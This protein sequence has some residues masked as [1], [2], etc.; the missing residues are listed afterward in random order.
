MVRSMKCSLESCWHVRERM[1]EARF[2]GWSDAEESFFSS[3]T[4]P[5]LVKE[6]VAVADDDD[7]DDDD[8]GSQWTQVQIHWNQPWQPIFSGSPTTK[9]VYTPSFVRLL[10]QIQSNMTTLHR[11]RLTH[12]QWWFVTCQKMLLFHSQNTKVFNAVSASQNTCPWHWLNDIDSMS[13]HF[14][15]CQG[16]FPRILIKHIIWC[17][18]E[19]LYARFK[20]PASSGSISALVSHPK[21]LINLDKLCWWPKAAKFQVTATWIED[22]VNAPVWLFLR[23]Q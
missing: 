1:V 23:H 14:N 11:D 13:K 9:K 7:G 3:S 8:D 5:L 2:W 16:E 18:G 15:W 20:V 4:L 6:W 19:L 17:K 12:R 10:A 21:P 22:H